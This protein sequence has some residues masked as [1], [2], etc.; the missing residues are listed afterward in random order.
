MNYTVKTGAG[1]G[2]KEAQLSTLIALKTV[3]KGSN[4]TTP[5]GKVGETL[6]QLVSRAFRVGK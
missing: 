3:Y 1:Y 6:T 2:S 5:E 4:T